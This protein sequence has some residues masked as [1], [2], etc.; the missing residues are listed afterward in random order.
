MANDRPKVNVELD[1]GTTS[2]GIENVQHWHDVLAQA[3]A[4]WYKGR[5]DV[6]ITYFMNGKPDIVGTMTENGFNP[7]NE[8]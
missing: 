3:T 7:R 8:E 1:N 2:L 4:L 6:T 5:K